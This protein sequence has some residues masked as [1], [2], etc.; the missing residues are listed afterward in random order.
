[1]GEAFKYSFVAI[2]ADGVPRTGTLK[3][4]DPAKAEAKLKLRGFS[5]IEVRG[6]G[7]SG[8]GLQ[9]QS[10]ATSFR[11]GKA[12]K[13]EY[14]KSL[15]DR[16]QELSERLPPAQVLLGVL[17]VLGIFA[18]IYYGTPSRDSKP[19]VKTQTE[20]TIDL[21]VSATLSA[22]VPKGRVVLEL[23]EIP[24]SWDSQLEEGLKSQLVSQ[25]FR[26]KASKKPTF[27]RLTVYEG[28][29][30]TPIRIVKKK[31]SHNAAEVSFGEVST[32]VD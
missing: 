14:Q 12:E 17:I 9:V 29:D 30:N 28:S 13:R 26:L 8:S 16:R 15:E 32:R 19:A 23:P 4:A 6:V 18:T 22:P 27:I 3:A 25:H 10:A 1:M 7:E 21:K 31:L 5:A 24:Y 11:V 2:D 20:Q